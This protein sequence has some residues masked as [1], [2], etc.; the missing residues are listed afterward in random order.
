[1][2]QL[3]NFL[4]N[5]PSNTNQYYLWVERFKDVLAPELLSSS[6]NL[7]PNITL[8]NSKE[9]FYKKRNDKSLHL[10]NFIDV[11]VTDFEIKD[12]YLRK[13]LGIKD[14]EDY[15]EILNILSR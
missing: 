7:L 12:K 13:K 4:D 11:S 9:V 8:S 1:M 14:F 10:P 5:F 2:I 15:N 3:V 6:C